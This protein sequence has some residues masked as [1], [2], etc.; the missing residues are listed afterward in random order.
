MYDG[1]P[2]KRRPEVTRRAE[3]SSTIRRGLRRLEE[4]PAAAVKAVTGRARDAIWYAVMAA[5]ILTTYGS[6][7]GKD[8]HE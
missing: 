8:D 2:H 4:D 5:L 1:F 6:L 7:P 3:L